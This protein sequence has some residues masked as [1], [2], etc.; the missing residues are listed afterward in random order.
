MCLVKTEL[1]EKDYPLALKIWERSVL[2]T[3]HFLKEEDRIALKRNT[4]LLKICRCKLMAIRW[5][6]CWFLRYQ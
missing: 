4:H 2:A 1:Q 3:H 5:S 6:S